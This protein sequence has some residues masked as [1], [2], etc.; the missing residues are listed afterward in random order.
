M[1]FDELKQR[2][3]V[4]HHKCSGCGRPVGHSVHPVFAAAVFDSG[5]DCGGPR[6]NYRIIEN[7]ELEELK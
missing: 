1:T 2:G 6:P 3:F 7:R 4:E 5:C